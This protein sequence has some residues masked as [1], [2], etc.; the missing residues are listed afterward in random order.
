MSDK[1]NNNTEKEFP[2]YPHYPAKE[3]IL[4]QPGS[5]RVKAD[6]ENLSRSNTKTSSALPEESIIDESDKHKSVIADTDD[7]VLQ[8]NEADV[9]EE[10]LILLDG[11]DTK[12]AKL[13]TLESEADLDIPGAEEDD[14]NEAIGE[15]DEENNYYS[16]GGDAH[17]DLE[18][19]K[20]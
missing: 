7:D 1:N 15:E 17:E 16:L 10:D 2:G 8:N 11:A 4:N 18:E 20:G 9:T 12:Q 3:D 6:V 13:D 5:E 19:D 14:A